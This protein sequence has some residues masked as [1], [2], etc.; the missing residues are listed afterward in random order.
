VAPLL[1]FGANT[2]TVL[3]SARVR[4]Q[5]RDR[6][7]NFLLARA[8]AITPALGQHAAPISVGERSDQRGEHASS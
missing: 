4:A 5:C 6:R 3:V 2:L 7:A 1:A 8:N